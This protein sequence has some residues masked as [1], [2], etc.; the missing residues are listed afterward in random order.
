M[1][2]KH[3]NK[4]K[5]ADL[6]L[7]PQKK[8]QSRYGPPIRNEKNDDVSLVVVQFGGKVSHGVYPESGWRVR[9]DNCH[10]ERQTV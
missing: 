5:R 10:S 6:I 9:D 1:M 8:F 4:S 3:D 7:D 2:V